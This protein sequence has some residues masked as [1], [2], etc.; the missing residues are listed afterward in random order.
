MP[1]KA[2]PA[3]LEIAR[4]RLLNLWHWLIP[5]LIQPHDSRV[6][7]RCRVVNMGGIWGFPR[8]C[9]LI[10]GVGKEGEVL[11]WFRFLVAKTI[12]DKRPLKTKKLVALCS[13]Y[14]HVMYYVASLDCAQWDWHVCTCDSNTGSRWRRSHTCVNVMMQRRSSLKRELLFHICPFIKLF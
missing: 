2:R 3:S 4:E 12:T 11:L 9:D 1:W 6:I 14:R 7:W 10:M 8:P 13:F 5:V